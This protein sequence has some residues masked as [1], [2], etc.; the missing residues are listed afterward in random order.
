MYPEGLVGEE[1]ADGEIWSACLWA[2]HGILGRQKADTI[3]L[4]SH[5]SVPPGGVATFADGARAILAAN[6]ALFA[7]DKQDEIMRIFA[8]RGILPKP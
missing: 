4:E 6:Q 5:Y 7:S 8:S 3:I 2:I 1:H